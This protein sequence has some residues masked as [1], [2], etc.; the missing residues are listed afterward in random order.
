MMAISDAA[1]RGTPLKDA[2]L[3]STTFPCH[4]CAR[5]IV[6]SGVRR[7]VYLEPY[8]KS[9]AGELSADSVDIES[10]HGSQK[11]IL[12]EP[13]VGIAPARYPAIFAKSGK[14]KDKAGNARRWESKRGE[15]IINVFKPT[16]IELELGVIAALFKR[17]QEAGIEPQP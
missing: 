3:F 16:Y 1:R 10:G 9:I 13:F 7:V 4:V 12:F 14:R 8:P 15:P 11:R 5:H 2:T 17:M 6:A